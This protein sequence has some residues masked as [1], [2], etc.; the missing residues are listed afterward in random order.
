VDVSGFGGVLEGGCSVWTDFGGV[1]EVLWRGL[2]GALECFRGVF[3]GVSRGKMSVINVRIRC[4]WN[5]K[6]HAKPTFYEKN[7]SVP[8]A[9]KQKNPKQF[10]PLF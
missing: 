3:E 9:R 6:N 4:K 10:A 8:G 2:G 5:L 7:K 1:F